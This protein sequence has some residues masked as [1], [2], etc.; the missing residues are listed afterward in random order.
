MSDQRSNR[1]TGSVWR[2]IESKWGVAPHR[3]ASAPRTAWVSTGSLA[4]DGVAGGGFARGR[5]SEV[6]GPE[7]SGKSTIALHAVASAHA[8]DERAVALWI[9]ADGAF[10]SRHA[11]SIGCDL[12]RL[13]IIRPPSGEAAFEI[14]QMV[15]PATARVAAIVIDS[16]AALLPVAELRAPLA[17][18][19]SGSRDANHL[20]RL[21]TRGLRRLAAALDA[22][23]PAVIVT[24]HLRAAFG[25]PLGVTAEAA[26]AGGSALRNF[27]SLRIRL[28]RALGVS[29]RQ[30]PVGV[31]VTAR[32]EKNRF[33]APGG[34]AEFEIRYG[35]G[36]C[37][38]AE[39]IERGRDLGAIVRRAGAWWVGETN[40]GPALEGAR[41]V[42]ASAPAILS[43]LSS[44][45]EMAEQRSA[46]ASA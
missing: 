33:A 4:L 39:L 10:D 8:A 13:V 22:G 1:A 14:A 34:E 40:L 26:G 27:A 32:I 15:T 28:T 37:R 38:L 16:A 31:R 42:I 25:E 23:G 24:N 12:E 46:R 29:D 6:I 5:I 18:A 36:I 43:A 17:T 45:I 7:G 20:A 19:S 44:A 30:R 21:L 9:D 2:A 3:A 35:H 41:G 11:A